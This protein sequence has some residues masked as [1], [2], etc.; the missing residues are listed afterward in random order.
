M[1]ITSEIYL[2]IHDD[3]EKY[4][5]FVMKRQV[6]VDQIAQCAYVKC[7]DFI[8]HCC[9]SKDEDASFFKLPV[10]RSL[11]EDLITITYLKTKPKVESRKLLNELTSFEMFESLIVQEKFF[12][13]YNPYQ[14]VPPSR[15]IP[16]SKK[17]KVIDKPKDKNKAEKQ[18]YA[19]LPSVYRMAQECGMEDLYMYIYHASSKLVHF[20]PDTLLKLGWGNVDE[21]TGDI[22]ATI[23]FKNYHKYYTAFVIFYS[24]YIFIRQ[25][26]EFQGLIPIS[27]NIKK[28]ILKL[29]KEYEDIDWPE[30]TT[31]DQL[32]IKGPSQLIRILARVVNKKDS[33]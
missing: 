11:C 9:T 3:M 13:K 12:E 7:Y 21:K 4:R 32:N 30:I 15:L 33:T 16:K 5:N 6:R 23:S 17:Q 19:T 29:E 8:I 24:S 28:Q 14:I 26:K 20:S 2:S 18:G 31:F 27:K 10:L 25:T 1:D 22:N